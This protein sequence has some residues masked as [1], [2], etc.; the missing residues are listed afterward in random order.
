[1][2]ENELKKIFR[3]K[4]A[5]KQRRKRKRTERT[6]FKASRGHV[7]GDMWEVEEIIQ[8]RKK[9]GNLEFLVKWK[10]WRQTYNSW[11]L[12]EDLNCKDLIYNYL[13]SSATNNN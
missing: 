5:E 3:K 11:L 7:D 13:I 10:H 2:E 12:H 9:N 1:M 4:S 8:H 6:N